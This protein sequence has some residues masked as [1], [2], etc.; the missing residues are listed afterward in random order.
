MGRMAQSVRRRKPRTSLL[1]HY[2]WA[3]WALLILIGLFLAV[4]IIDIIL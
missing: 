1:M 3:L 2:L 4:V